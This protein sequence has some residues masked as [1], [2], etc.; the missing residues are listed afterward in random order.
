ME[1]QN[2][3]VKEYVLQIP[4]KGYWDVSPSDGVGWTYDIKKATR[5]R[6]DVIDKLPWNPSTTKHRWIEVWVD[7]K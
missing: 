4:T 2:A 1:N 3:P 6:E 7:T 5:F